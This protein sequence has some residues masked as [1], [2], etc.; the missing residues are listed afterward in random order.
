LSLTS[1]VI[2]PALR[3]QKITEDERGRAIKT[4]YEVSPDN[5]N[6]FITVTANHLVAAQ[7]MPVKDERYY[8]LKGI[9]TDRDYSLPKLSTIN[10]VTPRTWYA[11]IVP[12]LTEMESHFPEAFG[13]LTQTQI[14][15]MIRPHNLLSTIAQRELSSK[16]FGGAPAYTV[17]VM[18]VIDALLTLLTSGTPGE[19]LTNLRSD[20]KKVLMTNYDAQYGSFRRATIK[21]TSELFEALVL[22]VDTVYS[23]YP[24]LATSE[25][26]YVKTVVSKI[27]PSNLRRFIIIE[28]QRALT[29]RESFPVYHRYNPNYTVP[30][31]DDEHLNRHAYLSAIRST[32][33]T[34]EDK[35]TFASFRLND[36]D[37]QRY[38]GVITFKSY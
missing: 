11:S 1:T 33:R 2:T 30:L 15:V 8:N 23:T 25:V 21:S 35:F 7:P 32:I 37:S 12:K 5:N 6:K 3:K 10:G 24:T 20:M 29:A 31:G 22:K 34:I 13:G 36:L 27:T 26:E 17:E 4:V 38:P 14:L 18:Q 19:H 16:F 9:Y 28:L